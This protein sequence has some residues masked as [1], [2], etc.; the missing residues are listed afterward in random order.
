MEAGILEKN[1][2]KINKLLGKLPRYMYHARRGI[3]KSKEEIYSD[4]KIYNSY[5]EIK[6]ISRFKTKG[7]T[8]LDFAFHG[9]YLTPC[10]ALAKQWI[11]PKGLKDG[12]VYQILKFE[13]NVSEFNRMNKK[14][15]IVPCKKW[16]NHIYKSR[17]RKIKKN[18]YD[19]VYGF[20]ADGV[21]STIDSKLKNG[22]YEGNIDE[23]HKDV[24]RTR[25]I[26]HQ[27]FLNN[28]YTWK[29]Y[30]A[31]KIVNKMKLN[32][33]RYH[34]LCISSKRALENITLVDV[35]EFKENPY[36]DISYIDIDK[37]LKDDKVYVENSRLEV[38]KRW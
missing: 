36:K 24:L 23:F 35:E 22:F 9:F 29:S 25:P 20:I 13:I 8:N 18:E 27:K 31:Y 34:Q 17:T 5:D 2:K 3:S 4:I 32:E 11:F 30:T 10:K 21:F 1:I 14:N 37:H 26:N 7:R 12:E 16:A 33:Y 19:Y 38:L 15:F 6:K 28:Y